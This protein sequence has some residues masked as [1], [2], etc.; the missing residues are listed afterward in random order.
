MAEEHSYQAI[1]K[2][3]LTR[4][5]ILWMRSG[6]VPGGS[7]A[8]ALGFCHG[9]PDIPEGVRRLRQVGERLFEAAFTLHG[10]FLPQEQHQRT[11]LC[12]AACGS[13]AGPDD[14]GSCP[15][16]TGALDL[17]LLARVPPTEDSLQ[18]A[19]RVLLRCLRRRLRGD[20]SVG[21][22]GSGGGAAAMA[23]DWPLGR[24][25][26]CRD[27]ALIGEAFALLSGCWRAVAGLPGLGDLA[28]P[29]PPSAAAA[30]AAGPGADL[31]GE[32]ARR[33]AE[34]LLFSMLADLEV[35]RLPPAALLTP[36]VPGQALACHVAAQCSRLEDRQLTLVEETRENLEEIARLHAV[37][38][39]LS[40]RLDATDARSQQCMQK[41]AD[42]N[43]TLRHLR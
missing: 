21:S 22:G 37:I 9:G 19:R 14:A 25:P 12:V 32:G 24:W 42:V 3:S 13:V 6:G 43:D 4:H 7:H 20:G 11:G 10:G 15:W 17:P 36:W 23:R 31:I 41:Q 38:A 34:E 27:P 28:G 33:A 1:L 30:A 39:Q 29:V 40:G 18:L 2:N 8:G 16:D 26:L 5:L 35:W